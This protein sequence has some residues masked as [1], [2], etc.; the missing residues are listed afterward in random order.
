MACGILA[1]AHG[2]SQAL[3]LVAR[4]LRTVGEGEGVHIVL[5]EIDGRSD[6]PVV[7]VAS[8]CCEVD[9]HQ[10]EALLVFPRAVVVVDILY[11]PIAEVVGCGEIFDKRHILGLGA[12]R[13]GLA[14]CNFHCGIFGGKHARA[15]G[16]GDHRH[17]RGDIATAD[18]RAHCRAGGACRHGDGGKRCGE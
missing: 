8:A 2:H 11:P 12:E 6:E 5:A 4:A 17:G 3:G 9:L 16:R 18:G 10:P 15:E 7:V 14:G 13:A 1:G